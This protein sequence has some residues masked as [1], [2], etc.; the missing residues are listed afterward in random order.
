MNPFFKP[1][2]TPYGVPAFHTINNEHY[3]PAFEQGMKQQQEEIQ[4]IIADPTPPNFENTIAA[5]DYSGKLLQRVS[6]VFFNMVECNTSDALLEIAKTITPLLSAHQD[7]IFLNE[8]L[9][10]RV[11]A[12]YQNRKE[13]LSREQ[14]MLLEKTH[15]HF[16]NGGAN[17][18]LEKR[19]RFRKINERLSLLSLEF[20]DNLLKETHDFLLVIDKEKDLE[21]LPAWVIEMAAS[22][23]SAKG[24]RDSWVFT[25]Q[26]PSW[27]PFLQYA[28]N[29]NLRKTL[30]EAYTKRGDR[31]NQ[32]DNKELVMEMVNLRLEKAKILG[33]ATWADY[34]L[35]DRMASSTKQVY[36][37][38]EKIWEKALPV[39]EREIRE[40]QQEI[41]REGADFKL[42][43]WD[44][45]FYAERVKARRYAFEEEALKPYF[46]LTNV[47]YKGVFGVANRLYGLT[48]TEME[49][50][51]R[52]LEEVKVFQV[53]ERDGTVIGILYMDLFVRDNKRAGAWMTEFCEQMKTPEGKH[54]LP[55][56]QV[57]TNFP[58]PVE[59]KPVL[60]SLEET[61]T[62][63]HEFG[64]ALHGLLSRC[65]YP[66]ISGTN[67]ARD[68]VELPSQVLE[69]WATEP[70]VLAQYA[71]HYK[72]GEEIPEALVARLKKSTTFHQG[73]AMIE[74]LSAAL[75]DMDFHTLTEQTSQGAN[76]FERQVM[77]RIGMLPEIIVRY[78]PSY[79]AHIF[80]GGYSA[81]YYSYTWSEVLDADAFEHFKERGLFD[82]QTAGAFREHILSKGGSDDPMALYVRFRGQEPSPDA[83]MKRKGFI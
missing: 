25:L 59:H 66:G 57:V 4:A 3:L 45:W 32:H 16:I 40:M 54:V 51:P 47:L 46:S 28:K 83:M 9:F 20:D 75:L 31:N 50:V 77:E 23:A 18:P 81:G 61:L 24:L 74:F 14:T 34:Q 43:P 13:M 15:R 11:H 49:E 7:N 5:I 44:W 17:L 68:F 63:F 2:H 64:H 65:T 38:L 48:F 26:K 33:Y 36:D 37:L 39:A 27:M 69:N 12:V 70:E 62:L 58:R 60:L 29:R 19:A 52:Y 82:P 55:V 42:E 67:V 35:S 71:R 56:I 22:T 73:F 6:G 21:G 72:T 80:S 30:F 41:A 10:K 78:R 53:Q 76:T 1:F 79:F 8:A